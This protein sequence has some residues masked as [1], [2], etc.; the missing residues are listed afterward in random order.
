VKVLI[1]NLCQMGDLVQATPFL[2]D[3]KSRGDRITLLVRKDQEETA[4]RLPDV[5]HLLCLDFATLKERLR[6]EDPQGIRE[7]FRILKQETS[8]LFR[9]EF[10]AVYN[11]THTKIGALLTEA[12]QADI[13]VGIRIPDGKRRLLSG[14][15]VR[16]LQQ[17]LA[18]REINKIHVV[19]LHRALAETPFPR[20]RLRF[21]VH[22]KD[23]EAANA[24][25]ETH[26]VSDTD[27]IIGFQAGA[28]EARK[29]WPSERFAS[30]ASLILQKRKARILLFGLASESHITEEIRSRAPDR[31]VNLAGKT[32]IGPLAALLSRC[33]VLISNDTGTSHLAAAVGTKVLSLH[34]GHVWFR[35]TAPYGEG[36]VAIQ[37]RTDCSPCSPQTPCR[38]FSCH[39]ALSPEAVH[40]TLNFMLEGLPIPEEKIVRNLEIFVS[41]FD[42]W[43]F[44]THRPLLTRAGEIGDSLREIL[45]LHWKKHITGGG[46]GV[47]QIPPWEEKPWRY[48]KLREASSLISRVGNLSERF[49]EAGNAARALEKETKGANRREEIS[50]LARHFKKLHEEILKSGAKDPFLRPIVEF[51]NVEQENIPPG[52]LPEVMESFVSVLETSGDHARRIQ[53]GIRSG[54]PHP[55]ST[56]RPSGKTIR[57][58]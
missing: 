48:G 39:N 31:I 1:I 47:S 6:K 32:R 12:V 4:R 7:A 19:D 8:A 52:T 21:R 13:K 50:R 15:A 17:I 53:D 55:V 37:V 57:K 29:R 18:M 23:E 46:I 44:L 54:A 22:G 20:G 26:G 51:Y 35:E 58:N 56:F 30:L 36:H 27:L 14:R 2:H 42:P 3:E 10:D 33:R 11:M 41:G 9:E 5:D 24:L 16:Y 28:N 45:G 49:R 38:S 43:N 34:L 40:H 25:L